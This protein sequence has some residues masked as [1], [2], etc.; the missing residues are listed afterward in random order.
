[1]GADRH[2][3]LCMFRTAKGHPA[4][5]LCDSDTPG[6]IIDLASAARHL[7]ANGND[8]HLQRIAAAR[9]LNELL[10][11]SIPTEVFQAILHKQHQLPAGS[12]IETGTKTFGES[13]LLACP[14]EP[15]QLFCVGMNIAQLFV[16]GKITGKMPLIKEAP[17]AAPMWWLKASTSVIGPNAP[18]IHPGSWHTNR[19]IPEPE[20]GLIVGKP[21]GPGIASPRAEKAL[22][23]LAGYC[24]LNDVSALDIEFERGGDPFAFN[25]SWS[26]SYPSFAPA[27]PGITIG[28][29]ID[30]ADLAVIMTIN[31]EV[32]VRENTAT[33]LWS[34]Q[35]LI[36]HFASVTILQPGDIIACGNLTGEHRIHPGDTVT[37][38][39]DKV[40]TLS[41]PVEASP[42]EVR[43]TVPE[44]V[45]N[46]ARQFTQTITNAHNSR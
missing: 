36:E 44:R 16:P 3:H 34:P 45:T 25:L 15:R 1:M 22:D 30:P 37:I 18:I 13:P 31:G 26:K 21:M 29:K 19:L 6:R 5:G 20:L 38:S 46:Y 24:V 32:R 40:G 10:Q 28:A 42:D 8:E 39:I 2:F 14:L 11:V 41:N 12:V 4:P 17:Y 9:T 7:R 27:G 33:Y 23:Y 35:E 43:Y